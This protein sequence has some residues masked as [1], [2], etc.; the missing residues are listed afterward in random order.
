[1]STLDTTAEDQVSNLTQIAYDKISS[2]IV[3]GR[4]DLGEP[5]SEAELAKALGVSKSPV[6]NAINELKAR[7][8]VEII[9]QSGT[10]VFTPTPE[11]IV[12]L[13]EF[14]FVLEEN[15]LR[16]AMQRDRAALLAELQKIVKTMQ[17]AW[18]SSNALDVKTCDTELHWSFIRHAG[19]S[20][21]TAA[22]SDISLLVEALRY[23]FMDTVSYRNKAFEE[24]QKIV[25]LLLAGRVE[26]VVK[27]LQDHVQRTKEF[28]SN[29]QWS[30][31][32]SQRKFYRARDYSKILFSG[33]G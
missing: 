2:A 4:L 19:N 11:K 27:L 10:Y 9:P 1:M 28:Q 31:G 8:L 14:R 5:L 3:Y 23:R 21:L 12:E 17:D 26:K 16:L 13:S 22:Y 24:H 6:R 18:A 30:S 29:A 20:Y 15:A 7:G 33:A 32:R 25:D